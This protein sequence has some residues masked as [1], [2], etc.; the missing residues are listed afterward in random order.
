MS[1]SVVIA[2]I[3]GVLAVLGSYVGNVSISRKKA[4][5]DA[6]REAKKEQS[7]TDRLDRLEKKVEEHNYWGKKFGD[8][9]ESI[10]GIQKD[11]EWLKKSG[12]Q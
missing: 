10:K 7:L 8:V 3:T 9:S 2:I 4:R 6:I 11:I 12:N 1:E 5:E